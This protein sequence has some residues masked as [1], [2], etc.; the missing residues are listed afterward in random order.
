MC[1]HFIIQWGLHQRP[2]PSPPHPMTHTDRIRCQANEKCY[3]ITQSNCSRIKRPLCW[4]GSVGDYAIKPVGLTIDGAG[5]RA[6]ESLPWASCSR[7]IILNWVLPMASGP[8]IRFSKPFTMKAPPPILQPTNHEPC[9]KKDPNIPRGCGGG[10]LHLSA[11]RVLR[12][13]HSS[14]ENS[15]HIKYSLR[16]G[17]RTALY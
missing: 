3:F 4:M 14:D 11:V 5:C 13:R 12:T 10:W 1:D 2:F 15:I 16:E 7:Q 17:Y 8:Q 6:W 9:E